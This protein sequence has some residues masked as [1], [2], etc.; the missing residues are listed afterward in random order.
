ML[1][2]LLPAPV[3]SIILRW[4]EWVVGT[5]PRAVCARGPRRLAVLAVVLAVV[6]AAPTAAV[7]VTMA[8]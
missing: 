1:F 2:L 6:L 3:Q 5:G 8:T 4:L 7:T